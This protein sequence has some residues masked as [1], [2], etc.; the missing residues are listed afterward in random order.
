MKF[1][2]E[3]FTKEKGGNLQSSI[4][5]F[6]LVFEVCSLAELRIC[7][8]LAFKSPKEHTNQA[9][10]VC[11]FKLQ[12]VVHSQRASDSLDPFKFF[13]LLRQTESTN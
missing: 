10:E 4:C 12:S 5:V 9:V 8:E 1:R 13:E 6:V 7:F 2:P 11:N 3:Q